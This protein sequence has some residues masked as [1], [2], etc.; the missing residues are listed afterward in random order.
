MQARKYWTFTIVF[1]LI[2]GLLMFFNALRVD[3]WDRVIMRFFYFPIL[4]LLV[5][6]AKTL[7]FETE[8]FRRL[9][10]P[11]VA[12]VPMSILAS[13]LTAIILN[14]LTYLLLGI[15]LRQ[16]HLQLMS[17]GTLYFGLFYLFWSFL[18]FQLAGRP[19]LGSA[20]APAT[21]GIDHLAVDDRGETRHIAAADIECL[22]A[23]GDYVEIRLAGESHLKKATISS[24]ETLLDP[25]RFRRVH[26]STIVNADKVTRITPRGSGAYQLT[27]ESGRV[28]GSSRSY[29][30]V[31]MALKGD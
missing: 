17:T 13:I 15:D 26:R 25:T 5:T 27:L 10:Y 21:G 8:A 6:S 3:H 2:A 20:P 29:R 23:S 1:W 22:A 30:S 16:H 4:A 11:L 24:L 19:L 18:Y 14:P 12:V 9:R 7:I 28:V 31:V